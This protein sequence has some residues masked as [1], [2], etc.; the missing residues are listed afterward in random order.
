M[1]ETSKEFKEYYKKISELVLEHK[2]SVVPNCAGFGI[3]HE[4]HGRCQLHEGESQRA[5]YEKLVA[6]LTEHG[7]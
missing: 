1:T 6:W 7:V 3:E 4:R 5:C 2:L